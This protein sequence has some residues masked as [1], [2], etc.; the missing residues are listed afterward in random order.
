MVLERR[1][2]MKNKKLN[3]IMI[4]LILVLLVALGVCVFFATRKPAEGDGTQVSTEDLGRLTETPESE[5]ETEPEPPAGFLEGSEVFAIFGGDS[6]S[7][8]LG[9]ESHSDSIMLV[10]VDHD[11]GTVRIASIYRDCMVHVEGRG[12]EKITHAHYAGGPELAVSTI[13]ENFDLNIENFITVN[14]T[15]V[16]ELVDLID[17]VEIE[18]SEKENAIVQATED[19]K[20]ESGKYLLNGAQALLFSRI[21]KIDTD[22]KRT[23]RQREVL[24]EIFGKAKAMTYMEKLELVEEMIEDIN[25]SYS[26]DEI[27][28]L[29]YSLSKYE[30]T[31]MTAYPQVF[32]GGWVEGSWVEVPWTLVDM[33]ASLH[34]F[35]Y[36]TSD[37][38][39]SEKV[40]EYSD[41]ISQKVSGPNHDKR[42]Q[43]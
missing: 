3:P 39:P 13:N 34:Q 25:T 35:L 7:G 15:N 1:S 9:K 22:Y 43:N 24:F 33:N 38:T 28:V 10:H 2:I 19:Q 41:Y 21:R 29:L 11:A 23:E 20:T 42:P 6:R 17:G 16:T 31:E 18:L 27:L 5:S 14:F 36:G 30:I 12:F 4:G 8:K 32:Y 40:Q 26:Q 37:Y